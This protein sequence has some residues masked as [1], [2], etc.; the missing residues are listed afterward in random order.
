M[1]GIPDAHD[2]SADDRA[3]FARAMADVVPLASD[4]KACRLSGGKVDRSHSPSLP[5][6]THR[7]L[8]DQR[9]R[10]HDGQAVGDRLRDQ[11]AIERVA[12]QQRQPQSLQR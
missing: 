1:P 3:A 8:C 2:L 5:D 6:H 10:C 11:H 7:I 9:I 4:G 12:V